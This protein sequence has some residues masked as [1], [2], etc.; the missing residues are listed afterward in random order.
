[1]ED[2]KKENILYTI[3]ACVKNSLDEAER[4]GKLDYFSME[5]KNHNG[6]FNMSFETKDIKKVY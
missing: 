1:M 4:Q 2:N 6:N 3:I 5:I